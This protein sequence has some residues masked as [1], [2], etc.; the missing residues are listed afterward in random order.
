MME[1]AA[2]NLD[3]SCVVEKDLVGLGERATRLR[4]MGVFSDPRLGLQKWVN[5]INTGPRASALRRV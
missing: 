4:V 3:L 2:R 1:L 5:F